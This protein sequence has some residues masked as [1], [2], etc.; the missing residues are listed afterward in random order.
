MTSHRQPQDCL[1]KKW[2]LFK[3]IRGRIIFVLFVISS[4]FA[5][6]HAETSEE[7]LINK[8]THF[9]IYYK[10]NAPE[11]FVRDVVNIS[12]DYYDSITEDLGFSRFNFW[13]WD[14]R[15]KIYIYADAKEYHSATGQPQWSQGAAMP[16]QKV[17]QTFVYANDFFDTVL[18]HEMR[19]LIFREFVGFNNYAVP[20]W[21]DEGIASYKGESKYSAADMFVLEAINKNKAFS[22]K[23]LS[24]YSS[25][26]GNSLQTRLF[27]AQAESIVG[28]LIQ[29]F[30]KDNFVEFC[31]DL[32]DN[33]NLAKALESAYD[34]S[35][36]EELED[37]WKEYLEE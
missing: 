21:L 29:D 16:L 11:Q 20:L 13:L 18:L 10:S 17:I 4:I 12:E 5:L 30:E 25:R 23:E 2:Y 34:F 33:K 1:L 26:L 31:Q 36:L 37:S 3:I 15:A 8:S 14:K 6:A 19:H 27:Y 28:F 22:I 9:I 7:W 32:R 24:N 35:S